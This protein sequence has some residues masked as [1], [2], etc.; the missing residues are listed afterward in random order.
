MSCRIC[1]E[2]GG[3]KFCHCTGTLGLVH[4]ECLEKWL[5]TSSRKECEIC[6]AKYNLKIDL[7]KL[8]YEQMV[9]QSFE[10]LV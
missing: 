5:D 10:F 8:F 1:L 7:Y 6:L 4:K 2:D 9:F 3:Q